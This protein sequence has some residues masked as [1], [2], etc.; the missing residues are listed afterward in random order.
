M[1]VLANG[2]PMKR[3]AATDEVA[4]CILFL[5]SDAASYVTGTNFSVDG[6]ENATG[7]PYPV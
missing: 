5:A 7:G 2:V 4:Q 1:K 6:G 3:L